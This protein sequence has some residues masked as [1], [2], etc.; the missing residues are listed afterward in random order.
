MNAAELGN[1]SVSEALDPNCVYD[2]SYIGN[3][4]SISDDESHSEDTRPRECKGYERYKGWG[5]PRGFRKFSDKS[6]SKVF[7]CHR[8]VK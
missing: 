3:D 7:A 8:G 2:S 1:L 5:D 4:E 6:M